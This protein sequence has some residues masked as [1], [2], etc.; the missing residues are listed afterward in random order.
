MGRRR[1][2]IELVGARAAVMNLL[3]VT[4]IVSNEAILID[5]THWCRGTA[6]LSA[7][8][9][10][11]WMGWNTMLL[12]LLVNAHGERLTD[13]PGRAD[14]MVRDLPYRFH[15]KKLVLFGAVTSALRAGGRSTCCG[16][17]CATRRHLRGGDSHLHNVVL[18]AQLAQ[19]N[20]A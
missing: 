7:A 6:L 3:L 17:A 14:G 19:A 12:L 1:R 2:T 10:T 9:F 20:P 15:W 16:A 13:L 18:V 8:A 11:R 5:P 4:H